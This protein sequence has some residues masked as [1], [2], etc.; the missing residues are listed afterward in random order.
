MISIV[1]PVYNEEENISVLIESILTQQFKDYKIIVVDDCSVDNTVEV[2]KRYKE[3]KL[4][5][6][7]NNSGPAK[8]RNVGVENAKGDIILFLDSDVVIH[9]DVL[10]KVNKF[11]K[12]NKAAI[13][14]IG[15]YSKNPVNKGFIPKFKAL[16][17]YYIF[18]VPNKEIVTSFEPRCGAVKKCVFE[19]I[20]GFDVRYKWLREVEDFEFG[21]RLLKKGPI[22]IDTSIQV[23]HNFPYFKALSRN[24]LK[25]GYQWVNLFLLRKK[26]DNVGTTSRAAF[27][28][29]SSFLSLILLLSS[30]FYFNL[31][32][33]AFLFF[34]IGILGN[35]KFY[36]LI[37]K[38]TNVLFLFKSITVDYILS[39]LLG[40]SA[41]VAILTFPFKKKDI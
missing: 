30:V 41:V 9:K 31:I 1:I 10:E 40:V 24:F 12:E 35:I 22:Y 32:Y 36:K 5:Q 18:V 6:L 20:G 26:F 21:Y 17:D 16:L 15:V 39:V 28:R 25:R 37:L 8:A 11:F 38:D 34:V 33:F 14:L 7:K 13:S 2:I 19:E 3:V 4:I 29:S 27:S 23:D